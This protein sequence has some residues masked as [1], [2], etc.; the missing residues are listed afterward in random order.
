MGSQSSWTFG[1]SC[2]HSDGKGAPICW[3]CTEAGHVST[4]SQDHKNADNTRGGAA[5]GKCS[6]E[7]E[8]EG[9]EGG[10]EGGFGA[11]TWQ[12]F[13]KI[14]ASLR[15]RPSLGTRPSA[16]A[17]ATYH[18]NQ[19]QPHHQPQ[20]RRHQ[21]AMEGLE[22]VT[23]SPRPPSWYRH[24]QSGLEVVTGPR[25]VS[26][27]DK[28]LTLETLS[29]IDGSI[30]LASNSNTPSPMAQRSH[31]DLTTPVTKLA[32]QQQQG[33]DGWDELSRSG[34]TTLLTAGDD[35]NT[36]A[37]SPISER[38]KI[39]AGK[40]SGMGQGGE[41]GEAKEKKKTE[42]T[43]QIWGLRK[44][45][46]W[47]LIVIAIAALT[48]VIVSVAVQVTK[49]RYVSSFIY[50]RTHPLDICDLPNHTTLSSDKHEQYE[51]GNSTNPR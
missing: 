29:S 10:E 48:A 41:E 51:G 43:K 24:S 11:P 20:Y 44:R 3:D 28:F 50:I 39:Q 36:T 40:E 37:A 47:I 31:W 2:P 23:S 14:R 49:S 9:E 25:V 38:G 19:Y 22:A 16:A 34:R 13:R 6:A 35:D 7:E 30:T 17:P 32:A 45:T 42:K 33:S 5:E 18:H 26:S 12:R 46:L 27:E 21:P 4:H 8:K 1:T 15:R